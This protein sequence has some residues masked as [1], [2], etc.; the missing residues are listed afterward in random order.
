MI[1]KEEDTCCG[2]LHHPGQKSRNADT[3]A[4]TNTDRHLA[5]SLAYT[6]DIATMDYL[7]RQDVDEENACFDSVAR[8]DSRQSRRLC[9]LSEK[10]EI[11]IDELLRYFDWSVLSADIPGTEAQQRRSAQLKSAID[12]AQH[13]PKDVAGIEAGYWDHPSIR[14]SV[15]IE[16]LDDINHI[17]QSQDY[18]LARDQKHFLLVAK[19]YLIYELQDEEVLQSNLIDIKVQNAQ[20]DALAADLNCKEVD[21]PPIARV[22]AIVDIIEYVKAPSELFQND[23]YC[24]ICHEEFSKGMPEG[25]NI[26][27]W[28]ESKNGNTDTTYVIQGTP[29]RSTHHT[30]K[31]PCGHIFG[32]KCIWRVLLEGK[33]CPICRHN[34]AKELAKYDS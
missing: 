11:L 3:H 7:L 27:V 22:I 14:E 28:R 24:S 13:I 19:T 15:V 4:E 9:S 20:R 23:E 34:Y 2:F 26:T 31:L 16:L 21:R 8:L 1:K 29:A 18:I 12:M 30:A 6:L 5:K 33:T 10:L 25:S 17:S 32:A